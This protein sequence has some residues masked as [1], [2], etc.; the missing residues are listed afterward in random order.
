MSF[1]CDR[2]REAERLSTATCVPE[3]E[4]KH[5]GL[6]FN[7]EFTIYTDWCAEVYQQRVRLLVH[8]EALNRAFCSEVSFGNF[9]A[10]GVCAFRKTSIASQDLRAKWSRFDDPKFRRDF[11]RSEERDH[12]S[13]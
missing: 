4:G 11:C 6:I 13:D 2:G 7:S 8:G 3:S 12:I 9:E 1:F 10:S 5:H